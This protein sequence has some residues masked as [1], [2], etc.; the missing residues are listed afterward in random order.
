M[1]PKIIHYIWLGPA[2]LPPEQVTIIENWKKIMPDYQYICWGNEVLDD[3]DSI[4]VKDACSVQKWAFASD[5]IRLWV[6]LKYGGIYLDTDVIVKQP[7]DSLL[8]KSAFIGR[9][10]FLQIRGRKTQYDLSSYC[11][12]AESG[13]PFIRSCL[14]YYHQRPFILSDSAFL[15]AELKWDMRNASEIYAR[16]ASLSGYN[17]SVL[18]PDEQRTDDGVFIVPWDSFSR[19]CSHLSSGS[20]RDTPLPDVNY[21]FRYKI[22]WRLLRI[23]STILGWFRY[24]LVKL[25]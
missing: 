4:F 7:F 23:V 13:H 15:P 1:I 2:P 8:E 6:L 12:G 14:D 5:V 22:E 25:R 16:I 10:N 19:F 21:T 18:S 3:I 17:P 24:T 20:W 11:L 9:E